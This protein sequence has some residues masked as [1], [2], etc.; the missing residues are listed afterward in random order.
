MGYIL[1]LEL[2]SLCEPAF[3]LRWWYAAA[4]A[5]FWLRW[6]EAVAESAFVL[7]VG[8]RM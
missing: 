3:Y 1:P 6:R 2:E 5:V 7:V 4:E 8:R